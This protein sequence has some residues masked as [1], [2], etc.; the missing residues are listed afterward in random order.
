MAVTVLIKR[1][2][3]AGNGELLEKLYHELIALAVQQQ[4]YIGAETMRRIDLLDEYLIISRWEKIDDWSRWLISEVRMAYQ[5][6]IDALTDS[7]T[8]FEIY[9]R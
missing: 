4:G 7:Y 3:I 6:R 8:R 2:V 9:G 1:K 5:E